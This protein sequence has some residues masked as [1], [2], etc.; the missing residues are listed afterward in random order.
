[1]EKS[2][3]QVV[4]PL[5]LTIHLHSHVPNDTQDGGDSFTRIICQLLNAKPWHSDTS[6]PHD[7]TENLLPSAESCSRTKEIPP[8]SRH[9]NSKNQTIPFKTLEADRVNVETITRQR[10]RNA[11]PDRRLAFL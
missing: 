5:Q 4:I 8:T 3:H 2:R 11:M 1:V 10:L 9:H 7:A 6:I